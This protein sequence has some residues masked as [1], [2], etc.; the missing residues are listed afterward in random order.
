MRD[1]PQET[2]NRA[3]IRA[4]WLDVSS[5][6]PASAA[7]LVIFGCLLAVHTTVRKEREVSGVVS[8]A[9]WRLNGDTGERYQDIEVTLDN[10]RVVRASGE[11]GT[12]PEVGSRVT[13][14]RRAMLLG[15]TTYQWDGP[16]DGKA[17][18]RMLGAGVVPVSAP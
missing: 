10:A 14:R 13:L 11:A 17:A 3:P 2:P 5:L 7:L 1:E 12:L 16:A 8:R 9:A 4:S 6:L 15:Y 18:P